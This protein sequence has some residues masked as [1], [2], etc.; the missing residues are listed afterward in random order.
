MSDHENT[1]GSDSLKELAAISDRADSFLDELE[2]EVKK[3]R[4]RFQDVDVSKLNEEQRRGLDIAVPLSNRLY[5]HLWQTQKRFLREEI[6]REECFDLVNEL[7]E[8]WAKDAGLHPETSKNGPRN[9]H[10][11][12][13]EGRS[14]ACLSHFSKGF[15]RHA[16]GTQASLT[17]RRGGLDSRCQYSRLED[18]TASLWGWIVPHRKSGQ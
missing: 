18:W 16:K 7:V 11:P 10:P 8:D 13:T 6:S 1:F 2:D 3:V 4:L 15:S 14:S 5:F 12:G 17:L 9:H